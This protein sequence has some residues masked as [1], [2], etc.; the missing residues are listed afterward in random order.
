[1]G[2]EAAED[3]PLRGFSDSFLLR[4]DEE[5]CVAALSFRSSIRSPPPFCWSRAV[6]GKKPG[7][8][9]SCGGSSFSLLSIPGVSVLG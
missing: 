6:C 2:V 4:S 5:A 9:W 3:D 7:S 8:L 1:M